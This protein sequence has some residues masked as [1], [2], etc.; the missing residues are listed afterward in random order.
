[1]EDGMRPRQLDK[2]EQMFAFSRQA[3]A[4]KPS[5]LDPQPVKVSAIGSR[6]ET[7]SSV[8]RGWRAASPSDAILNSCATR[9]FGRLKDSLP[10]L[11]AI[12]YQ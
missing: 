11:T 12:R 9:Q 6:S 4:L 10:S 2:L 3:Q 8:A 5:T 7:Y 1:M